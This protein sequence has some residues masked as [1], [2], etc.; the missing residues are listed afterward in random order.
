MI[1]SDINFTTTQIVMLKKGNPEGTATGFFYKTDD[2][3]KYLITN[4]HVVIDENESFYPDQLKIRLHANRLDL[5]INHEIVINLYD[6][7]GNKIWKE[8]PQYS[9]LKCDVIVV[10]LSLVHFTGDCF[11]KY[12]SS[13][14]TFFGPELT[15]IPEIN[16]FGDVVVVGYPLGFF[17]ILN[18]LPVYR[19]AMIAS[20]YG[21]NFNEKPYFLIDANLHPGTSGSPVINSHHTLFREQGF[22]EGYKLF[23]IQSAQHLVNNEPLGLNVVWYS[24][25]IDEIIHG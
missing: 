4:R 19:K 8:H 12:M 23:G 10:P 9:S 14:L 20:Q 25:L 13:S 11:Q 2:A 1:I 6:S 5:K 18:N 24:Y 3:N 17:D 15:A 22:K 7:K 21:V 16:P